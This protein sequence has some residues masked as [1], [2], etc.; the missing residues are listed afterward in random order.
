MGKMVERA[1]D[2]IAEVER[3]GLLPYFYDNAR[4]RERTGMR[5]FEYQTLL[6]HVKMELTRRG[7]VFEFVEA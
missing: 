3:S 6:G 5:A 7:V 1:D 4:C 2:L